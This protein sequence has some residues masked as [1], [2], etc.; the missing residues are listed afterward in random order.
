[1]RNPAPRPFLDRHV[2]PFRAE[3]HRMDPTWIALPYGRD[4]QTP[5]VQY[6]VA[7]LRHEPICTPLRAIDSSSGIQSPMQCVLRRTGTCL[8]ARLSMMHDTFTHGGS[9]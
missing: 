3:V 1:M 9:R 2:M 7:S 4:L 5:L 8:Q 6:G